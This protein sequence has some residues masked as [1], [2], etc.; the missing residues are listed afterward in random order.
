MINFVLFTITNDVTS[1]N[2]L[3]SVAPVSKLLLVTYSCNYRHALNTTLHLECIDLITNGMMWMIFII[4]YHFDTCAK[5]IHS[6]QMNLKLF[7]R[8]PGFLKRHDINSIY[9]VQTMQLFYLKVW[10]SERCTTGCWS[11]AYCDWIQ[12]YSHCEFIIHWNSWKEA[13][14]F[15]SLRINPDTAFRM[16]SL[17][18][19]LKQILSRAPSCSID[20]E[21]CNDLV[22]TCSNGGVYRWTHYNQLMQSC[23]NH[24]FYFLY[25]YGQ[26][27]QQIQDFF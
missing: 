7:T 27:E 14:A 17:E 12:N 16:W 1:V 9:V 15:M 25:S 20:V 10:G 8:V 4:L 19:P 21:T 22:S 26:I 3:L 5:I 6:C 18:Y 11:S 13:F 2:D 23:I 24:C